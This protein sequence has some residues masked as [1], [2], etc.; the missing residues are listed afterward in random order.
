MSQTGASVFALMIDDPTVRTKVVEV[1]AQTNRVT[2]G[3]ALAL[4]PKKSFARRSR[5]TGHCLLSCEPSSERSNR[6]AT[7]AKQRSA[8]PRFL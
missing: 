6:D 3:Q 1:A 4:Q 2:F 8:R 7:P 5:N